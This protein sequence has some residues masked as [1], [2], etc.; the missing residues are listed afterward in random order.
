MSQ[1]RWMRKSTRRISRL[2][3]NGTEQISHT[4]VGRRLRD[5]G[6]SLRSNRKRLSLKVSPDRDAQFGQIRRRRQIF[7]RMGLPII[8]VDT[9]KRELVGLFKNSGKAWRKSWQDV[10]TYD[11][12]SDAGG[13]AIPYGIHDVNRDEGFVV[14]G[15]SGNTPA[16]AASAI[17]KWWRETGRRNYRGA[18]RI[19]VLADSGGSNGAKARAWKSQLQKFANRTGLHITVAHYPPGASKWNPVEHRLLSAISINWAG[20]PLVDYETVC[21]L[22][23]NTRL[24]SGKLCKVHLDTRRW[25]TQK[26]L[27]KDDHE[28]LSEQLDNQILRVRHARLLPALNYTIAPAASRRK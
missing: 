5:S 14:V 26:Q 22:I 18:D 16:F 10:G 21:G 1:I 4:T 27:A 13:V 9:K 20:E 2:L 23:A 3:S 25:P 11:F 15:T 17:A 8:S 24:G 28:R 12:P 19:L 6:Y 7:S